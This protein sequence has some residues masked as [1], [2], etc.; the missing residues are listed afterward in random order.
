MAAWLAPSSHPFPTAAPLSLTPRLSPATCTPRSANDD[1][2]V[3][4]CANNDLASTLSV[5]VAAG[6]YYFIAVGSTLS[7]DSF[8]LKLSVTSASA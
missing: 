5:G 4:D 7:D 6:R 2:G 8:A 3:V 1:A